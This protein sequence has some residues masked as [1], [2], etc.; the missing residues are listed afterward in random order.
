M[1]QSDTKKFEVTFVDKVQSFRTE[2]KAV[3]GLFRLQAA[4]YSLSVDEA[5]FS[6]IVAQL[7]EAWKTKANIELVVLGTRITSVKPAS[8]SP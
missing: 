3:K 2:A 6:A 4:E 7:A 5:E 1:A 8:S